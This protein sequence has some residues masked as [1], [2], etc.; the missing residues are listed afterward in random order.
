MSKGLFPSGPIG[1]DVRGFGFKEGLP[2][3]HAVVAVKNKDVPFWQEC[4]FYKVEGVW[5]CG[6]KRRPMNEEE[7]QMVQAIWDD[8][9]GRL[10][11]IE[12]H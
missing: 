6:E 11:G 5:S 12:K 1:F 10:D 7:Q 8:K 9:K 3:I 2:M 4:V